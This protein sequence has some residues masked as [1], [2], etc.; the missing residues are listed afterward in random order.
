MGKVFAREAGVGQPVVLLHGLFGSG[1][2]LGALSRA[3][4]EHYRVFSVDLP[5]HG[6]SAVPSPFDLAGMAASV[7]RWMD[8]Q[9]IDKASFVGHSLGGKVAMEVA[10][11]AP[12]RVAA[13]V[14]ADIAPVDYPPGHD[15]VFAG[16]FAVDAA[17]CTDRAQAQALLAEHVDDP[18]VVQFLLS[19]L[20]R[21][22]QGILRWRLAL[23]AIHMAYP[24]LSRAPAGGR[25]YTGPV[26]FIK[27]GNSS[28]LQESQRPAIE[29]LF[30]AA[31]VRVL[32]DTGHWLHVEKPDAFNGVVQRFLTEQ[33][34]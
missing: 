3:L 33:G 17:D 29:A 10:L 7:I 21:D 15:G 13:L 14:V 20:R 26:L 12:G 8:E 31:Q 19:D 25:S 23:Q 32:P 34:L 6:A 9:D 16:L 2:N 28:Y 11:T 24:Q 1:G 4:R 5:G 18:S 22:N 27:G 30:P